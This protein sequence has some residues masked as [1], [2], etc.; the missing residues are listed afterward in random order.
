MILIDLGL[1]PPADRHWGRMRS[2]N[3]QQERAVHEMD[4]RLS[5][6]QTAESTDP[7]HVIT[8]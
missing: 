5:V 6:R 2:S 4:P 3:R 1:Q 7:I 8:D